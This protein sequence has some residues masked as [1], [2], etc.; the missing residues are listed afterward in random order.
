MFQR[1]KLPLL[2]ILAAWLC[3]HGGEWRSVEPRATDK[4]LKALYFSTSLNGY[5]VGDD[6]VVI[7]TTDGGASW[8][9]QSESAGDTLEDV[10][11]VDSLYGWAVG[12]DGYMIKSTDGGKTWVKQLKRTN[13]DLIKVRFDTRDSGVIVPN[14]YPQMVLKTDNGG[15]AWT[16]VPTG[17]TGDIDIFD[18]SML[19]AKRYWLTG[20]RATVIKTTDSGLHWRRVQPAHWDTNSWEGADKIFFLN[21]STGWVWKFSEGLCHTT[22]GGTSWSVFGH[23]DTNKF[24]RYAFFYNLIFID[25]NT[26]YLACNSDLNNAT[27]LAKTTDKGKTWNKDASFPANVFET[28]HY[29]WFDT[30]GYGWCVGQFGAIYTNKPGVSSILRQV[31]N[32]LANNA[33]RYSRTGNILRVDSK[34]ESGRIALFDL[35]GVCIGKEELNQTGFATINLSGL[36]HGYYQLVFI[37]TNGMRTARIL[38]W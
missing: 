30:H 28:M 29:L 19:S 34:G 37:G 20:E 7:R 2:S 27:L 16:N 33:F 15:L 18:A 6:G 10:F 12:K 24:E 3:V 35:R 17:Y 13:Y 32:R 25:K 23:L 14:A 1:L 31:S 8:T 36:A 11:F 26:G 22:N 21:D 5:A 4:A 38:N 9:K